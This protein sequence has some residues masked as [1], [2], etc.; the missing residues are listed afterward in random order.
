MPDTSLNPDA[1]AQLIMWKELPFGGNPDN[2]IRLDANAAHKVIELLRP[3]LAVAQPVDMLG[4]YTMGTEGEALK[5]YERREAMKAQPEVNSVEELDQ[6]PAG[7]VVQTQEGFGGISGNILP[8]AV[9]QP[10][11][12]DAGWDWECGL[13]AEEIVPAR[14]LYR[15]TEEKP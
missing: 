10:H 14:V 13:K 2:Y 15:P 6:L 3:H 7:A 11:G 12:W 4:T 8:I 1:L 9:K 5:S